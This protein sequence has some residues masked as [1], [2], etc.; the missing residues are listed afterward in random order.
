MSKRTIYSVTCDNCQMTAERLPVFSFGDC[1]FCLACSEKLTLKQCD[2]VASK[3]RD[4]RRRAQEGWQ[5]SQYQGA[6][7]GGLDK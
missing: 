1:D 5:M 2:E 7:C 4:A 3:L 6:W